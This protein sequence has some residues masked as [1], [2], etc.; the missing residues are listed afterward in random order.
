MV[1]TVAHLPL[2]DRPGPAGRQTSELLLGERFEAVDMGGGW[3]WGYCT[4]DHYVGYVSIDGLGS[5]DDNTVRLPVAGG[6]AD[7]AALA[8]SL[9]GTPFLAGG[10]SDAGMDDAGLIQTIFA[11]FDIRA[12]RD[13]D[14]QRA[15]LGLALP[16]GAVPAR[17][18]LVFVAGQV[19]IMGDAP[20][21]IHASGSAGAVV[22]EPLAAVLARLGDEDML[23]RRVMS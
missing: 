13:T 23:V 6:A 16:A 8:L 7:P 1:C 2:Y 14:L 12:P 10:R 17:N 9:I 22:A 19:G 4:H 20:T 3:A 21:L 18:D 11:P 15:A 5:S